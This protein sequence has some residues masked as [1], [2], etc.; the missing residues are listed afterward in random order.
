MKSQ[1]RILLFVSALSALTLSAEAA[2]INI[3]NM[4]PDSTTVSGFTVSGGALV[5]STRTFTLTQTA[6]LD[7]GLGGDDTL[8]FDLIYEAYT[9]STFDGTDVTLGATQITPNT[10]NINW[11]SNTF[12][13]G[14]TLYLKVANISYT[15][16]DSTVAFNG[17][18]G[19]RP[20][21]YAGT[22]AGDF[23][24]YIGLLG[25]TTITGDP[26]FNASLTSNGTNPE[27]YFTS[28]GTQDP[29][30]LRDVDFQFETSA[31]PEPTTPAMILGGLGMLALIRRRQS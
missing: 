22:G 10:N 30:R 18:T 9:G 29:V 12:D 27:L 24:Y 26:T 19:I 2:V 14:S 3:L 5:G 1:N 25:A 28:A 21:N 23:D 17:F 16:S 31:I 8:S 4:A 20:A 6:D 13:G 15:S 7:G 11:H